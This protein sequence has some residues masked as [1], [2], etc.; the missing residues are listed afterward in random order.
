[1][2]GIHAENPFFSFSFFSVEQTDI[3]I[4]I[5]LHDSDA[6]D[7]CSHF[8]DENLSGGFRVLRVSTNK[9]APGSY[10]IIPHGLDVADY[11]AE[12]LRAAVKL[13]F[14]EDNLDNR[15]FFA[16]SGNVELLLAPATIEDWNEG[17]LLS[18][19]LDVH[20][21]QD[22]IRPVKCDVGCDS[23]GNCET[24]C[25]CESYSGGV[26]QEDTVQGEVAC[27]AQP[28]GETFSFARSFEN[29]VQCKEACA[30]I[31]VATWQPR[32]CQELL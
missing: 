2:G 8:T 15:S 23:E 6:A 3:G 5:L 32:Y 7:S 28:E 18:A 10:T 1:M 16:R 24:T 22:P 25:T 14:V 21:L 13:V 20:F 31:P 29:A 27:C 12:D 11:E 30:Q 4:E 17:Q 19:D 9:T 26:V